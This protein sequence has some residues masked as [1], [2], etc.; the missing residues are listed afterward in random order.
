VSQDKFASG[1]GRLA[2][3]IDQVTQE[4]EATQ[5]QQQQLIRDLA[6]GAINSGQY[7]KKLLELNDNAARA[8]N[9]FT[10]LGI[11]IAD[12]TD[13][14]TSFEEKQNLVADAFKDGTQKTATALQLFGRGNVEFVN[15]M[16]LGADGIGNLRKEAQRLQIPRD[17]LG[18]E[19]R[20]RMPSGR[21]HNPLPPPKIRFCPSS[22]RS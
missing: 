1:E 20:C 3:A 22:T 15:A 4:T 14:S 7:A 2:R 8:V 9:P 17:D 19:P 5:R 13:K 18:A 16:N 11:S 21:W 6:S 12:I 10:R